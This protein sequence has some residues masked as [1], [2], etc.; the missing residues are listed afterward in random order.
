MRVLLF[1]LLVDLTKRFRRRVLI[2][3]AWAELL[4]LYVQGALPRG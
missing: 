3:R 1:C 4:A 2:V